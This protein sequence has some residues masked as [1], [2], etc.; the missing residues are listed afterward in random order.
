MSFSWESLEANNIALQRLYLAAW[1]WGDATDVDPVFYQRFL[2]HVNDD[3]NMPR[4][5]AVAWELVKSGL[6]KGVKKATILAFD[7]VFGLR[8][9]DW[10]PAEVDIPVAVQQLADDRQ[11]ARDAKQWQLADEIR[12]AITEAGFVVED[13]REGPRLKPL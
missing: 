8:I 1:E 7:E 5:L 11:A 4:A 9:K 3:L 6:D 12:A 13:S 10:K 2:N